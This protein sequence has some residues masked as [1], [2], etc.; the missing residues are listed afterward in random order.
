MA[1]YAGDTGEFNQQEGATPST[2]NASQTTDSELWS[3]T[4]GGGCL[5]SQG[6]HDESVRLARACV[7]RQDESES[8]KSLELTR[9]SEKPL[10]KVAKYEILKP[11]KWVGGDKDGEP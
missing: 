3:S 6:R 1:V 9:M 5:R 7:S 10:T 11:E 4:F 8:W 2:E